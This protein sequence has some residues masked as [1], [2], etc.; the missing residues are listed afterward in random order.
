[1]TLLSQRLQRSLPEGFFRFLAWSSAPVYVDCVEGLVE[2]AGE[3]GRLPQAEARALVQEVVEAHSALDWSEHEGGNLADVRVKTGRI[4][5]NLLDVR[6]LED[7]PESLHDRWVVISPALRPLL[8]ML[9]ELSTDEIGE[10]KSF[11]DTLESACRT[12]ESEGILDPAKQSSDS[13]RATV[14]EL[15]QRLDQAISQLH[16]VE[17]VIHSFEQRQLHSKS[18]AETLQLFYGDFHEGQHMVCY[19]VLHRRGLLP[20][21]SRARNIVRDAA[22]NPLAKKRLADGIAAELGLPE[23]D[24]W[25]RAGEALSMLARALGGIRQRA[26]AVDG[27]IA[28]FHQLSKQ[29]YFYQSQM[30]NRRPELA[31][32]VCDVVNQQWAGRKFS[33]LDG[34][35]WFNLLAPEVE[36]FYG[37]HLLATPKHGRLKASLSLGSPTIMPPDEAEM[38]R[39]RECQR[40]ALTPQRAARLVERLIP[41]KGDTVATSSIAIDSEESLL[42]LLAAASFDHFISAAGVLR[43]KVSLARRIDEISPEGIPRDTVW[44]WNV[45]SFELKRTT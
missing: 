18:G 44:D 1:M 5:N 22:E 4:F 23:D 26:T 25:E 42:N 35:P 29:R 13:F 9:R 34:K 6:W 45:E 17:K 10:L 36:L 31:K 12:L 21:L 8:R 28:S 11:A 20:R 7:R 19:D 38:E 37:T 32:A 39:L 30:R 33:D 3:S 43:W 15:N 16:A 41:A 24:A 40:V 2:A 14:S 27:R